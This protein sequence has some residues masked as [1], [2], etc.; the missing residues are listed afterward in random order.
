MKSVKKPKLEILNVNQFKPLLKNEMYLIEGGTLICNRP[1]RNLEKSYCGG[2]CGGEYVV[3][4]DC[5]PMP[6]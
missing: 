3:N 5:A 4:P 6:G 2:S 1:T